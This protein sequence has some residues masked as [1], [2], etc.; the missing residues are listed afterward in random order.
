MFRHHI[1]HELITGSLLRRETPSVEN[2]GFLMLHVAPSAAA[3]SLSV[4]VKRET[5]ARRLIGSAI[6]ALQSD[7]GAELTEF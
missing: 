3:K 1:L 5:E 4:Q 6:G 2:T 7:S